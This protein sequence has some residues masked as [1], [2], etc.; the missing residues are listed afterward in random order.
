[1]R[2]ITETAG[3]CLFGLALAGCGGGD[4]AA[5]EKSTPR[6]QKDATVKLEMTM[7]IDG[8]EVMKHGRDEPFSYVH[9]VGQAPPGME[10]E[11]AG[12]TA[13]DERKFQVGPAEGFGEADPSKTVLLPADQ[14]PPGETPRV[15]EVIQG[16]KPDGTFFRATIREVTPEQVTLDLNHPFAGKTLDF[17]VKV[18]E[19][20]PPTPPTPQS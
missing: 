20:S 15:G 13:G 5:V 3:L 1:M 2:R 4:S 17:D 19:V 10:R 12:L 8:K 6:I 18:L 9:G 11:L 14:V 7:S 16:K